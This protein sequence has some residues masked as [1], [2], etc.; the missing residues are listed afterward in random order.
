MNAF[1]GFAAALLLTLSLPGRAADWPWERTVYFDHTWCPGPAALKELGRHMQLEMAGCCIKRALLSEEAV[2]NN[3]MRRWEHRREKKYATGA[4]YDKCLASQP[5]AD[6]ADAAAQTT[7]LAEIQKAEDEAL[8]AQ[9]RRILELPATIRALSRGEIC[10]LYGWL[11]RSERNAP[12][13]EHERGTKLG[14][15]DEI[16][17][18]VRAEAKRRKLRFDDKAVEARK[19]RLGDTDCHMYAAR[20]FPIDAHVS[21]GRW[22][23]HVQHVYRHGVYIYTENGRVTSMQ[24]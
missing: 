12:W 4:T 8:A 20:G 3:V 2:E 5:S 6:E 21:V 1:L 13:W 10:R 15:R 18:L 16:A 11:L 22:G 19:L 17:P 14:S 23:E 7:Y 9:Q 24:D